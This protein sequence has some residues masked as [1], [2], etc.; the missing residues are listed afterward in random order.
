MKRMLTAT[1]LLCGTLAPAV[2]AF[3][4]GNEAA[5]TE[6]PASKWISEDAAKT[7]ATGTGLDVRDIKIENSCYEIYALDKDGNR[8]QVV[9][10]PVTGEVVGNEEGED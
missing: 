1:L 7:A 10:N 8:V 4:E 9:M 6:E 2:P 3:A 5:C